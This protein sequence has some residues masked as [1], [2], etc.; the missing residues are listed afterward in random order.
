MFEG[1]TQTACGRGSAATGPFYCPADSQI[2][3]DLG[4]F[5]ELRD[6]FGAPG[7]F[8]QART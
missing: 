7:D 3:L 8:A 2:Y 5:K 1:Q 6:R 4:F